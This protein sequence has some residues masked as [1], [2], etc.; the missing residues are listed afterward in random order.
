MS[1]VT[2]PRKN[3]IREIHLIRL[4]VQREVDHFGGLPLDMSD[5]FEQITEKVEQA[6]AIFTHPRST[7]SQHLQVVQ[8]GIKLLREFRE[9]FFPPLP[10][11]A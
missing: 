4:L 2:S 8:H 3:L 5:A 11:A 9:E 6:L 10:Y 7:A 1:P